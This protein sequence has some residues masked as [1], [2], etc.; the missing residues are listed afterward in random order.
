LKILFNNE[1]V[2][3]VYFEYT[4]R[5]KDSEQTDECNLDFHLD[6][7]SKTATQI[8]RSRG[9]TPLWRGTKTLSF[10][11][12]KDIFKYDSID[13]KGKTLVTVVIPFTQINSVQICSRKIRKTNKAQI[14]T[15]DAT[16][17]QD[18]R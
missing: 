18:L 4:N 17:I 7:V 8:I 10:S 13:A 15:L 1:P 11:L 14:H 16:T 12:D 5:H 3:E 9:R 6:L 2:G